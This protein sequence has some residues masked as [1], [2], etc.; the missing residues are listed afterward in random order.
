[1]KSQINFLRLIFYGPWTTPCQESTPTPSI[2]LVFSLEE[3]KRY[4]LWMYFHVG[5]PAK[6]LMYSGREGHFPYPLYVILWYSFIHGIG[7]IGLEQLLKAV[8]VRVDL[9]R[10]RGGRAGTSV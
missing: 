5:H 3:V 4:R 8:P 9:S 10:I 7:Q 1:M 6:A 2:L